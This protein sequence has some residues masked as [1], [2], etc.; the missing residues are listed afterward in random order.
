MSCNNCGNCNC[1]ALMSSVVHL[2]DDEFNNK[3][4][5]LTVKE[6]KELSSELKTKVQTSIQTEN[7]SSFMNSIKKLASVY[8][9]LGE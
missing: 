1:S 4:L 7:D 5:L 2:A 3:I 8:R 9:Q 6:L